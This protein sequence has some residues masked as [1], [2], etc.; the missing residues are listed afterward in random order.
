MKI[1]KKFYSKE[2]RKLSLT[3]S[4]IRWSKASINRKLTMY[5]MSSYLVRPSQ[6]HSSAATSCSRPIVVTLELSWYPLMNKIRCEWSSWQ[7]TTSQTMP[8]RRRECSTEGVRSCRPKTGEADSQVLR[9]SG[10]KMSILLALPCQEAL[11]TQLR[12]QSAAAA[13]QISPTL[14]C[15]LM[16]RSFY[17]P[18]TVSGNSWPTKM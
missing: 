9:G 8:R 2:K 7:L 5:S 11:E 1:T 13:S 16:T 18:V 6:G 10:S 17:W 15:T 3:L 14:S 12:T 4:I